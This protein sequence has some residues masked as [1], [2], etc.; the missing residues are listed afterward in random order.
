MGF[1]F[2]STNWPTIR[3][4]WPIS[5]TTRTSPLGAKDSSLASSS[6]GCRLFKARMVPLK[7]LSLS[8]ETVLLLLFTVLP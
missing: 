8:F 3:F 4:D 1:K 5:L 2:P 7:G 6:S